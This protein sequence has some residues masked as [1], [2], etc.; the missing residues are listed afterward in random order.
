MVNL[1]ICKICGES[2]YFHKVKGDWCKK[3]PVTKLVHYCGTKKENDDFFD[4]AVLSA[5]RY[6]LPR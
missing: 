4:D 1:H 3:G 2:V 6:K 5:R